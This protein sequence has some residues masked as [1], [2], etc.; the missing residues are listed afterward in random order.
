MKQKSAPGAGLTVVLEALF[1]K[2]VELGD[3]DI[4]AGFDT[5]GAA[6]ARGLGHQAA[7]G[8]FIMVLHSSEAIGYT[9]WHHPGA[10][11]GCGNVPAY[12][13]LP[14]CE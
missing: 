7:L 3:R 1:H 11:R 13:C 9:E 5:N 6:A 8:G 10:G 12:R 4:P 2:P 14:G